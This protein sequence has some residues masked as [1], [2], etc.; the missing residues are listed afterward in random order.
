MFDM[1]LLAKV[2][3]LDLELSEHLTDGKPFAMLRHPLVYQVPYHS[4]LNAMSNAQLKAKTKAVE[5]AKEAR[6][7]SRYISL[8]ERPWRMWAFQNICDEMDDVG[9]WSSLSSVWTDSENINQN[10]KE[11]AGLLGSNRP[12][13]EAMMTKADLKVFNALPSHIEVFRGS[14]KRD[15]YPFSWTTSREKAEWFAKRQMSIRNQTGVVHEMIVQKEQVLAYIGGRN[16]NEIVV[17]PRRG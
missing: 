1:G 11:W 2:E 12:G 14:C 9:Y 7:W 13:R 17:L 6:N 15:P 10:G 16:E 8:H 3:D 5:Q 4:C